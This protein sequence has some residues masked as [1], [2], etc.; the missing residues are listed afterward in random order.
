MRAAPDC[1]E[2]DRRD[3]RGEIVLGDACGGELYSHGSKV[4]LSHT[5][6]GSHHHSLCLPTG[7]HLQLKNNEAGPSNA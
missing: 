5:L 7:Q 6:G 1:G 3:V 2:T 4:I